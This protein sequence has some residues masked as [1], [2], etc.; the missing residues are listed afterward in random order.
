MFQD[1]E[2]T[3]SSTSRLLA[4]PLVSVRSCH[5]F[6]NE[7]GKLGASLDHAIASKFLAQNAFV[8]SNCKT[9]SSH[10]TYK[11]VFVFHVTPPAHLVGAHIHGASGCEIK[12][13]GGD[14][15]AKIS[16]AMNFPH[17][18]KFDLIGITTNKIPYI[19]LTV[20]NY[21]PS[22]DDGKMSIRFRFAPSDVGSVGDKLLDH[23]VR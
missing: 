10:H 20:D 19:T 12:L 23:E 14:G 13:E 18:G 3:V 1:A 11:L 7:F 4:P 2:G 5:L 17:S 16:C 6:G 22:T 8:L 21:Q 9:L 15:P